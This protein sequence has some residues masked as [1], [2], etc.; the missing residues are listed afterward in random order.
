MPRSFLVKKNEIRNAAFLETQ[1]NPCSSFENV[2]IYTEG[3]LNVNI[4][5]LYVIILSKRGLF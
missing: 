1:N 4:S 2:P 5:L 3:K